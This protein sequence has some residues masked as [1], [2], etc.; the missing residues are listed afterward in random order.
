MNYSGFSF[1]LH[2]ME[3]HNFTDIPLKKIG[4]I[5]RGVVTKPSDIRD[6]TSDEPTGI[7]FLTVSDIQENY[8]SP[9]MRCLKNI[10]DREQ[11]HCLLE[12]DIVIAKM[13]QP[14]LGLARNVGSR[15]IIVSQN[16]YILRFDFQ[17]VN[18]VYI[19]A[20]FESPLG[21]SR[22]EAAY[23][24][25]TIPTLPVRNLE[26]LLIPL[27]EPEHQLSG[28]QKQARFAEEY[29]LIEEKEQE[30]R[31]LAEEERKKRTGLFAQ[32]LAD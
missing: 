23:V 30:F 29:L 32:N 7:F 19:R 15:K 17:R 5:L 3:T 27:P 1:I 10:E 25:S 31:F 18:P 6:R 13:G 2:R 22:L 11:K 24:K 20:F 16:L 14:K 26:N 9:S 12:N 8:L 21:T 28:L 4:R